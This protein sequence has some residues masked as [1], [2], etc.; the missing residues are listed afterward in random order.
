MDRANRY[1]IQGHLLNDNMGGPGL[2]YNM[3][4]LSGEISSSSSN[5]NQGHLH[6]I[7]GQAKAALSEMVADR[8]PSASP[9][10]NPIVS[11]QYAV[12]G[13]WRGH[14]A[15]ET[16]A[17]RAAAAAKQLQ[18]IKSYLLMK[19][20]ANPGDLTIQ[21][22]RDGLIAGTWALL[23][24][25]T[26]HFWNDPTTGLKSFVD[27]VVPSGNRNG[28]TVDAAMG[29]MTSNAQLWVYEN[30]NVPSHLDFRLKTTRRNG[31]VDARKDSLENKIS[32]DPAQP[33]V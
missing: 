20:V 19:G 15:R 16:T 26:A 7:E 18:T 22:L 27:A 12:L 17:G 24:G 6:V 21:E 13:S 32:N 14:G 5:V 29:L 11:I 31:D 3:T 2:A 1:Y 23:G 28:V 9:R 30:A 33:Y 10:P 4:P 8:N 25:S